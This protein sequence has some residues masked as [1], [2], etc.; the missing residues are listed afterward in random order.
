MIIKATHD[1]HPLD[2]GSDLY[3]YYHPGSLN[4][5]LFTGNVTS[6]SD[7]SGNARTLGIGGNA[8][9]RVA[10]ALNGYQGAQFDS[11]NGEYLSWSANVI[12]LIQNDFTCFLVFKFDSGHTKSNRND[13]VWHLQQSSQNN[14]IALVGAAGPSVPT[15]GVALRYR[16]GSSDIVGSGSNGSKFSGISTSAWGTVTLKM[17]GSTMTPYTNGSVQSFGGNISAALDSVNVGNIGHRNASATTNYY[18]HGQVVE[19][20]FVSR[21]L[22]DGPRDECERYLQQKYQHY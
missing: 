9:V 13:Y 21:A 3:M 1:F 14:A 20:I 6:W 11:A 15:A 4:Y 10:S 12:P 2:F 8:P 16:Q 18:F 19:M 17:S 7:D 22:G 5:S